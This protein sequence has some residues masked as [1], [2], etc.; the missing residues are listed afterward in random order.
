[1]RRRGAAT[2]LRWP[3]IATALIGMGAAPALAGERAGDP[4]PTASVES[5]P[6]PSAVA[7]PSPSEVPS[8][9]SD[10]EP[11]I[12]PSD[13]DLQPPSGTEGDDPDEGASRS[14]RQ[15]TGVTAVAVEDNVFE[16]AQVTVSVGTRVGWTN[17]GQNPHTVT[18][19]DGSF[20]SGN[21]DPGRTTSA[22]FDEPG[23]FPYY[24]QIHGSPGSGMAGT[25]IVQADPAPSRADP[26]TPT[27]QPSNDLAD[28]GDDPI[29]ALLAGLGLMIAGLFALRLAGSDPR[30]TASDQTP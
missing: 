16:P 19:N 25:V 28:T 24:C 3:V 1:M 5:V 17:E 15:A 23:S 21:L 20:D 29:A 14:D 26:L 2:L 7:S 11:A 8:T 13:P 30:P 18:A 12:P 27:G 9:R 10:P 6:S 4:T 22:T